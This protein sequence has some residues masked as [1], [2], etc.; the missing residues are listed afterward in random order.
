MPIYPTRCTVCD[1]WF[2]DVRSMA[3]FDQIPPC[4][5]CAGVCEKAYVPSHVSLSNAPPIVV[6]KAPDGT[7]RFPGDP[8]GKASQKYAKLGYERIE[9][10]GQQERDRLERRLNTWQRD[11]VHRRIERHQQVREEGIHH[12][13]SEVTHGMRNGFTIPETDRQG[14]LTGRTRT[15]KLSGFG[16]DL[17]QVAMARNDAKPGPQF[18]DPGCHFDVNHNDRGS[19]DE[20]RRADGKRHRD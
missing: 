13:R 2:E 11:E 4:P 18:R 6:F 7:Y 19:R 12:R 3:K 16:R 5:K 20:S 15:V 17:M 14:R 8:N 9:A 10:R 1:H